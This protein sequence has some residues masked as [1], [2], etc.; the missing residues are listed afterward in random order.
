[1]ATKLNESTYT[2]QQAL[3]AGLAAD[4]GSISYVLPDVRG[5]V[6]ILYGGGT[7]PASEATAYTDRLFSFNGNN[8]P[9]VNYNT[10][11]IK[12]AGGS[13]TA[14]PESFWQNQLDTVVKNA[15]KR[16]NTAYSF[17]EY[18]NRPGGQRNS[19]VLDTVKNLTKKQ[20]TFVKNE[21]QKSTGEK[22]AAVKRSRRAT[23]GLLSKVLTPGIQGMSTGLPILG[24]GGLGI[25][26]SSLGGKTRL[27]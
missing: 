20:V 21:T 27:G 6:A 24:E 25:D 22:T 1:M 23:G 8:P 26:S 7:A 4:L 10:W 2:Y 16:Q 19:Q 3:K 14:Q 12:E 13:N 11:L 18:T 5:N 17:Y 15:G 9:L